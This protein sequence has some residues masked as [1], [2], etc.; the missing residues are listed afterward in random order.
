M[1]TKAIVMKPV[2][3]VCTVV[4]EIQSGTEIVVKA[5]NDKLVI[6]VSESIPFGH[7]IAI[8]D[9]SK[10]EAIKKYGE[11]IGRA[12]RDIKTGQHVHVHNLESCRGRGDK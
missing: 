6:H 11:V 1:S 10:G 7:K 3:N 2:D 8:R 12:T 5:G 9:I 4:E